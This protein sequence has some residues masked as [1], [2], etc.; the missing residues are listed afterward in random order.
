VMG[1]DSRTTTGSYIANRVSDKIT[2]ISDRIWVCRSGSAADT[3]A[4]AD[5]VRYYLNIHAMG[6]SIQYAKPVSSLILPLVIELGEEPQVK[7]AASLAQHIC[8][9]NKNA[10]MAG[11]II[12]G[13]DNVE[14]G[15][16]Y[17]IS[18]GGSM[19]KQPFAIGG[20][21]STYIYGYCD[22]NFRPDMSKDACLEFVRNCTFL[23][24]WFEE[25]LTEVFP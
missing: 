8:Y 18:L 1:A 10:L 19:V 9:T 25:E 24:T 4:I 7:T 20:S 6:M 5:Y 23:S 11:L 12:A 21:G 2:P 13:W 16:V 14:G 22:A 17:N 3:Q 15:V